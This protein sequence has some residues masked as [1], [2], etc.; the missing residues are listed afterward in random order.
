MIESSS[1]I[2][3]QNLYPTPYTPI[4]MTNPG[5]SKAMSH[6]QED[7]KTTFCSP[8]QVFKRLVNKKKYGEGQFKEQ[9]WLGFSQVWSN[10]I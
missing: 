2:P 1:L 7:K 6:R 5:V 3:Y 8:V 4:S 10:M 9:A